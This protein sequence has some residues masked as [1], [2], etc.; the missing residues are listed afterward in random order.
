MFPAFAISSIFIT[1]RPPCSGGG[2][3]FADRLHR[4]TRLRDFLQGGGCG[5]IWDTI[6]SEGKPLGIIPTCFTTLDYLRVESSLLFYP[7]DMSQMYPFD[8][9]P[10]GDSLWELGLDF[11]V[12]PGKN[13]FNGADAHARL[14]GKERFKIF[15]V[16]ADAKGPADMGDPV[17]SGD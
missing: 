9:D 14:K 5:L 13:D 15:G 17:Y 16:L 12:S 7:Y 10:P 4:G 1:R 6:L 2:H 8:K 3:D 11:T